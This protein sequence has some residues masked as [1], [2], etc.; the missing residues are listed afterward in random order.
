M[1]DLEKDLSYWVSRLKTLVENV[2][3]IKKN[4]P[5]QSIHLPQVAKLEIL[6]LCEIYPDEFVRRLCTTQKCQ[7]ND[8]RNKYKDPSFEWMQL[9][10][11]QEKYRSK[12]K[13]GRK[14]KEK[15]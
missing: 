10:A 7:L 5:T 8:W 2:D 12:E 9:R 14:P 3:F 4:C 6:A 15:T 13:R 11:S 1:S